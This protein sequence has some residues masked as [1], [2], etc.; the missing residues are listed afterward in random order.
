ML[1]AGARENV[2]AVLIFS[3]G[4]AYSLETWCWLVDEL[5]R[6][7]Q[8]ACLLVAYDVR[9][10]GRTTGPVPADLAIDG[11]CS[12]LAGLLELYRAEFPKAEFFLVG[13]SLGGA[14]VTKTRA[15]AGVA[16]IVVIDIVEEAALTALSHMPRVL[17]ARPRGFAS[18]AMAV[19]WAVRSRTCRSQ[20][21]AEVSF[22]AQHQQA[23][24]GSLQQITDLASSEP[25]WRDWFLGMSETF[26]G[27]FCSRL[28]VLAETDYLDKPLLIGLMQGKYQMEIVRDT[29]HAIQEDQPAK[30][31]AHVATFIDRN[32]H[33]HRLNH[34]SHE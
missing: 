29:G 13:H 24:D 33:M 31:A 4:A 18:E 6:A 28:L 32:M 3:H 22:L 30:L 15:G 12:D 14:V 26:V 21:V 5:K 23:D 9:G 7:L 17:A 2:E 11:L 16:G 1:E 10:H 34:P 19:A 25:H 8:T 27:L 20:D